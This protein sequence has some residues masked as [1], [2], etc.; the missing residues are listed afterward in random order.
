M[1]ESYNS[2]GDD[3]YGRMTSSS[4]LDSKVKSKSI[5]PDLAKYNI[6]EDIIAKADELYKADKVDICR[7]RKRIFLLFYYT[8]EAYRENHKDVDPN[9]IGIV[10][11]LSQ[12]DIMTAVST[13]N[14]KKNSC[15]ISFTSPIQ[16]TMAYCDELRINDSIIKDEIHDLCMNVISKDPTLVNSYPQTIASGI[17]YYYFQTTNY[18]PDKAT[19]ELIVGRSAATIK[20]MA[21]HVSIIDN[22]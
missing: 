7:Q 5:A 12:G 19:F 18:E 22:A 10:F 9:K 1:D 8:L 3:D 16:L 2:D 21:K 11:G 17:L 13:F 20:K 15:K 6:P 14:K 4:L